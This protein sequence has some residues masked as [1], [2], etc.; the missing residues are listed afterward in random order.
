MQFEKPTSGPIFDVVQRARAA[1]AVVDTYDQ[2]RVDELVDAAG[3]AIIE[4]T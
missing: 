1:Q 4:P 2:T 3:W